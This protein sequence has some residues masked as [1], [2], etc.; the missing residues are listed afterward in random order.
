MNDLTS[1]DDINPKSKGSPGAG[2]GCLILLGI[3]GLAGG[4]VL[5]IIA[6]IKTLAS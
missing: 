4:W 5:L 6:A 2:C 3:L 1:L